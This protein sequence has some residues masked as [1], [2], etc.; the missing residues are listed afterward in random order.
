MPGCRPALEGSAG[1]LADR[2]A[3]SQECSQPFAATSLAIA[4]RYWLR[5]FALGR[6]QGVAPTSLLTSKI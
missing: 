4:E 1:F 2:H 5:Y 3:V 6:K